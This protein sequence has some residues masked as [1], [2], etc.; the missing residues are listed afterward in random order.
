MA[1]DREL[2]WDRTEGGGKC[3]AQERVTYL[4][5]KEVLGTSDALEGHVDLGQL[6]QRHQPA[7]LLQLPG[8][9]LVEDEQ[10]LP[11]KVDASQRQRGRQIYNKPLWP[12]P[13]SWPSL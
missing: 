3:P 12:E 11:G 10:E 8:R 6:R 1:T 7:L 5:F 2:P 4:G 9:R 13:V